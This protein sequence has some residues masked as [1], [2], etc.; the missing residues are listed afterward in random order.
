MRSDGARAC[1]AAFLFAVGCHPSS[2]FWPGGGSEVTA[3]HASVRTVNAGYARTRSHVLVREVD[4]P[5][6][7]GL[8][9][10]A[11]H[12][13][14]MIAEPEPDAPVPAQ[15]PD[16]SHPFHDV[17]DA[18]TMTSDVSR[19]PLTEDERRHPLAFAP[20][21]TYLESHHVEGAA[22]LTEAGSAIRGETWGL[23]AT[24]GVST[25]AASEAFLHRPA[26]G[27]AE[28][29]VKIEFAP[30]FTPFKGLADQDGDGFPEVYGKLRADHAPA[31]AVEAWAG[32]YATRSL[33]P[34]EVKTWANELSS[35][36][37]PSF[38][39]DLVVAGA[40]WPDEHTEADIRQE[41]G[42]KV[43]TAPSIVMRGKPE[44]KATYEVFLVKGAAAGGASP[45]APT[46][47]IALAKTKPTPE[48]AP[49][50]ALVAKELAAHG[51]SWPA[52]AAEVTPFHADVKKR[53]ATLSHGTKALAGQDG[54]LYYRSSLE[55]VVGGDLESQP[56]GKNP[57]PVIVAFKKTLEAHGVDFL[58]VP[59]PTK[60]EILPDEL[61][62][63]GKPLV[64][65]VVN[66]YL[67][68]LAQ[69]LSQQGVEV[70]DL[71]SPLL[72]ARAKDGAPGTEPLFQHQD[73]HWTDRGLRLAADVL[74]KRI[75]RYPWYAA[76][77][78]HAQH[79][80]LK[81]T[82]F[83]RFG[84]LQ[85]RLPEAAQTKYRP[86]ALVGHQVVRPDGTP[87]D[88][89]P[90][91][92]VVILGDSFTGVYELTDAEHAGVSAHVARGISYP[93]DLVMSYG[94]GP[95]VRQ[96]LMRRG[97][98]ALDSKKLVVWIMTARDLYHYF[99]AWEPLVDK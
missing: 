51:G 66:P 60:A 61:S 99:E 85:S 79:F 75:A 4:V 41:L 95:N 25:Q 50:A 74:T 20:A 97:A 76:L 98:A 88:D 49:L 10:A 70:V 26:S 19:T 23:P 34:A 36:W 16:T 12:A 82:S 38:N 35:Y 72:A 37:Y 40:V 27:P 42:G 90:E 32:D 81:E 13:N 86:E 67:L 93:V 87:Y 78:Q 59:V 14:F 77:E 21:V 8:D 1:T 5:T 57:L 44:G 73:T 2:A 89:D 31:A 22:T 62:E 43:F 64:G 33:A 11:Y 52:W 68:K 7:A 71:L 9:Y 69:D 84:D 94:G 15:K 80:D 91:S 83:S 48:P 29:W 56:A 55:Y 46:A 65:K 18:A 47:A 54:F 45:S 58:F 6:R 92:P 96:K 17:V 53:L 30:W 3:E 28:I 63:K 24:P 39:T